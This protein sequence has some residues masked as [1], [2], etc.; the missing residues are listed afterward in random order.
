MAKTFEE[1]IQEFLGGRTLESLDSMQRSDRDLRDSA[2]ARAR[3]A[4]MGAV[5]RGG[6]GAVSPQALG[7]F[8]GIG[9]L[10]RAGDGQE[11]AN[12]HFENISSLLGIK[13]FELEGEEERRRTQALGLL[14]GELGRDQRV[15][16]QE[17]DMLTRGQ[18]AAFADDAGAGARR[19]IANLR[20]LIGA[21]G[22][23]A[24]S[25][26]SM[27]LASRIAFQQQSEVMRGRREATLEAAKRSAVQRAQR[28]QFQGAIA[29]LVNQS[30][31]M[32]GLD[33]LTNMFDVSAARLSQAD[34]IKTAEKQARAAR[35]SARISG[36]VELGARAIG[37]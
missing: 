21:R 8:L 9:H 22:L 34:E 10:S 26:A 12:I 25:G 35:K 11:R 32:L 36:F 24:G 23:G 19:G 30:P 2:T 15:F 29:N 3:D 13:G 14:R 31:S 28:A 6:T 16:E 4:L 7:R 1:M 37:L 20:S 33:T 18:F 5:G 17:Q 27:G